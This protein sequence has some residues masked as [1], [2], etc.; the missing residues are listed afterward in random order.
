[1]CRRGRGNDH[2]GDNQVI[3]KGPKG[4]AKLTPKDTNVW[5]GNYHMV[6]SQGRGKADLMQQRGEIR[7]TILDI[8]C[9]TS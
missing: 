8:G 6:G 2:Y 3:L 7:Y 4:W 1:M 5:E 9:L